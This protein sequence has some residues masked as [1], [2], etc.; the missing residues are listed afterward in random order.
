MQNAW[1]MRGAWISAGIAL[2]LTFSAVQNALQSGGDGQVLMASA[3]VAVNAAIWWAAAA[4]MRARRRWSLHLAVGSGVLNLAQGIAAW[5]WSDTA[6]QALAEQGLVARDNLLTAALGW[7]PA[8]G[9]AM[10]LVSL[11]MLGLEIRRMRSA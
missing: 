3:I 7:A 2:V 11:A 6:R 5:V 9:S 4:G 8:L 10:V 1:W